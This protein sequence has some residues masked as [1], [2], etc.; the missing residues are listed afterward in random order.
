[1]DGVTQALDARRWPARP[2]WGQ[3]FAAAARGEAMRVGGPVLLGQRLDEVA[4]HCRGGLVYLATPYTARAMDRDGDWCAEAGQDAA[5]AAALWVGHLAEAGVTA[6]SPVVQAH[7]AC[8]ERPATLD[9]LRE[10]FWQAWCRPILH[11][12]KSMVIPEIDGW[13][14]SHG[15]WAEFGWA[16]GHGMPVYVMACGSGREVLW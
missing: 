2:A 6:I 13:D 5:D 8:L 15:I 10:A 1:M 12:C 3:V 11:R 16:L 9:P 4:L 7:A 14:R